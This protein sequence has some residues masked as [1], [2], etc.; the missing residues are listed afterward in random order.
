MS[1]FEMMQAVSRLE[2][3]DLEARAAARE[4][5]DLARG[6][7]R[8]ATG[9]SVVAP[10]P[11]AAMPAPQQPCPPGERHEGTEPRSA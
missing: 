9:F 10:P 4:G 1:G 11:Q 2:H 5:R 3:L 8:P 7:R 6:R